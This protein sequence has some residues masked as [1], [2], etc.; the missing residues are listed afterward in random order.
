MI[1]KEKALIFEISRPGRF[2]CSLPECDVPQ[3]DLSELIPGELLRDSPPD[4]PAVSEVDLVRHYTR[5]SQRNYGVDA[6]FYPLGSCTMKYNPK[7]NED[8]ACLSGFA[9]VHPYQ[10]EKA[11]QGCLELL[12]KTDRLLSEITGMERFLAGGEPAR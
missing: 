2:A 6:G 4:L 3:K 5:L 1:Q 7:V 8:M 12:W 11:V 10:D 9:N